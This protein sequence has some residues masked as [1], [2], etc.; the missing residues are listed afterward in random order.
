MKKRFITSGPGPP[1]A[2]FDDPQVFFLGL[3][4]LNIP[5]FVSTLIV[6]Q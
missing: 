4:F 3:S 1:S 2:D 5:T 6:I